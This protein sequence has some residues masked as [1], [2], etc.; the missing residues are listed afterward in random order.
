MGY[1]FI[2]IDMRN[3]NNNDA[4]YKLNTANQMWYW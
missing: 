4:N 2:D 1:I 3:I